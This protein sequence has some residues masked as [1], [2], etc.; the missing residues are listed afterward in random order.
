MREHAASHRADLPL[1][2]ATAMLGATR[3]ISACVEDADGLFAAFLRNTR[4]VNALLVYWTLV[5]GGRRSNE[6][7]ASAA[8][9]IPHPAIKSKDSTPSFAPGIRISPST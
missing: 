2:V 3:V 1:D 6:R 7:T 9:S 5:S 4:R 8:T